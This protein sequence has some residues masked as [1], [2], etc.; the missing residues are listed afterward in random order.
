MVSLVTPQGMVDSSYEH[1]IEKY[2][3]LGQ[4]MVAMLAGNPLL[5]GILVDVKNTKDNFI[6]YR[7]EIYS[8]FVEERKKQINQQVY[9]TFGI[10]NVYIKEV[11]KEP[12][13]NKLMGDILKA[14]AEFSLQ[15]VMILVGYI[16]NKAQM[17][18]I[19]EMG[20]NDFRGMNFCAIGTGEQHAVNTL[21]IHKHS[22][23][24]PILTTVYHVYKAKKSAEYSVG[25]GKETDIFILPKNNNII[26]ID[27]KNKN[28]LE[29][30]YN[31]EIKYS[32]RSKKLDKINIGGL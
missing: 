29:R 28:I 15:T 5:F 27:N 9:N 20:H 1:E 21:L 3:K 19:S 13:E 7:D 31:E 23:K 11:L 25:V 14:L 6:N 17:S 24:S 10:D 18:I 16:G 26:E 30:I 2:C 22:K 32:E 8:N 4:N 12:I